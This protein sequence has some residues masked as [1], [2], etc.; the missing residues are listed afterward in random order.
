MNTE[1]QA[2]STEPTVRIKKIPVVEMFGPTIEGEGALIGKQ[3]M[4]IRFGL[5]DYKCKRCDSMH[6]VD[7]KLVKAGA[8][9]MEP[10]E[11]GET[12]LEYMK[13]QHAE[14]IP[15]VTFSGGNPAIHDLTQLV[16]FLQVEGKK[17]VFVETQG[18]KSPDWMYYVDHVVVSPKS[19]GMG[20]KFDPKVFHEFMMKYLT[21]GVQMSVKIPVFSPVDLE[22]AAGV[23]TF[24]R[25]TDMHDSYR[26]FSLERDFYLSLGNGNPPI[27]AYDERSRKVVP[28]MT[29]A[30]VSDK[31]DSLINERTN[32]KALVENLLSNYNN[33]S[34]KVMQDKR[35]SFARF[36]PQ[37][38]VLVWGNETGK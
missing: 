6:A 32:K 8:T 17:K 19:P 9:Y 30:E 21:A 34:A 35:I 4:F 24:I 16:N 25:E 11:I 37:L 1:A 18:T 26:G 33:L 12:L 28:V 27:F 29:E 13:Q 14:H 22:F 31:N 2:E 36:L 3:T 10:K 23:A 20:E 38:H 7:P 5:C 15:N